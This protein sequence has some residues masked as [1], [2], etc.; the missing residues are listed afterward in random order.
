MTTPP[1][2]A[3]AE[4]EAAARRIEGHA[5]RTPLVVSEPMSERAGSTI[6]IKAEHRQ[7][8]GS[9]KIRGALN[10][11]YSL[12]DAA[13]DQGVITASS[14][15]HGIGVATAAASRGIPCTVYLPAGAAAPKVAAIG[16]LG[17]E[18]VTV[19]DVDTA[20][21]ESSARAASQREGVTYISPYNDREIVAGQG[22]IGAELTADA[23]DLGL[24]Q[25]DAVVAAVGGGGLIS[26][27][28]SW[29][30]Q[31]SPGTAMIGA[32]PAND[33]A[34]AAS[35]AAGAIVEP[36]ASATYSDG[37]A[38]AVEAGA[39][40]FPICAALIDRW[41]AVEEAA[42]AAAVTAMVDDHHELVEGAAGVALAAA[43]RYGVEN[44]GSTIVVVSCGANI[45]SETLR[46]MLD[47]VGR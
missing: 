13:A 20:V 14:G 4:I 44:P 47:E 10:K 21:A 39:I 17:A 3:T 15:N 16:R 41:M 46:R 29:I 31:R 43:H 28:A 18:I 2:I 7:R 40:T 32:S 35:V 9:F 38:G 6:V 11:A 22:T 36:P 8:T 33:Q 26:G 27:I 34:M 37:T 25:V 5:I 24:G 23:A 19:D 12:A 45:S 42:I 1:A 30:K